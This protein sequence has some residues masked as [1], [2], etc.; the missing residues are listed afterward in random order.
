VTAL[1]GIDLEVDRGRSVGIVGESGC[2]KSTLAKALV[3]LVPITSGNILFDGQELHERRERAMRRRIQMVFQDPSSSLNPARTVGQTLDELLRVHGIVPADRIARRSAE[4]LE[5]VEL[6]STLL[7]AYPRNLSGGQRQRVGIA[8][9]LVL[10]PDVLI[11]DEAVSAL[12]VSVQASVLNLLSDLQRRLDLT[13]LVISHDLAVVRHIS[14]RIVVMYL[15]RIVEDRPG[16]DL[17]ED[18]RHPYTSALIAAAPTLGAR[19][20]AGE[21]ALAGE[22]PGLLEIPPGCR[23]H[24]RCPI[25][26]EICRRDDPPLAGPQPESRV[27]CHFA[28]THPH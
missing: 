11:A 25:A 1:D 9:A 17:F 27:A 13:L 12:D 5:L 21:T 2:G 20:R 4:I 6:P 7:S 3:G 28:W 14:E 23:F 10:E 15:G 19:K 16:E 24:P 26:Q 8:R 18:P 22:P